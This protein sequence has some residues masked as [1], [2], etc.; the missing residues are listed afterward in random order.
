MHQNQT[1][2][3]LE[4]FRMCAKY[5]VV[6]CASLIVGAPVLADA[7]VVTRAMRASTIAEVYVDR[8]QVRVEIEIGAS[9][10]EAFVNCLPDEIFERI[11]GRSEP[12]T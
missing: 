6:W 1:P 9:D 11:T 12:L 10:L 5:A 8:E 4:C 7:L 2:T 3:P